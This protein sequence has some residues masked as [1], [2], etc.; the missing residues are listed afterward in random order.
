MNLI[1]ITQKAIYRATLVINLPLTPPPPRPLLPILQK[2]KSSYLLWYQYYQILPK[3]QRYSLGLK[4]DNLFCEAIEALVVASFS[5]KEEKLSCLESAIKKVDVLRI[6]LMILWEA[7]SLDNKKYIALS[8]KIDEVGK[9]LGGWK[10][11]LDKQNSLFS[12]EK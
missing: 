11:Q 7:K 10:G 1:F 9:M 2:T 4:V 8:V 6:F 5:A 3:T 12:R